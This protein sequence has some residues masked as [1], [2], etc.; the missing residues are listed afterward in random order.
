[1]RG[2]PSF[3]KI[4]KRAIAVVT[5]VSSLKGAQLHIIPICAALLA[6]CILVLAGCGDSAV[7]TSGEPEPPQTESPSAQWLNLLSH[8]DAAEWLVERQKYASPADRDV[9]KV[10]A[11]LNAAGRRFEESP[12]MIANRALQLQ[13]MLNEIGDQTSAVALTRDLH[14]VLG[15]TAASPGFGNLGAY[16]VNLRKSGMDRSIALDALTKRYDG[17]FISGR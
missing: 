3:H 12:R 6:V 5:L 16:Y 13:H 7:E 1:M 8:E 14:N 17:A 15:G 11:I 2:P 9:D 4:C 10:R